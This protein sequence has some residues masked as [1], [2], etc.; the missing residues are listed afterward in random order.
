M[1]QR[2]IDNSVP[3]LVNLLWFAVVTIFV[4]RFVLSQLF[5]KSVNR[6][7]MKKAECARTVQYFSGPVGGQQVFS[8]EEW[9]S[10]PPPLGCN[11][12]LYQ[13]LGFFVVAL[14]LVLAF[15][16]KHSSDIVRKNILAFFVFATLAY[17]VDLLFFVLVVIPYQHIDFVETL[18]K[19]T[20]LRN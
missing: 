20:D 9:I 18:H 14:M 8:E 3:V 15:A 1:K 4:W 10:K 19:A 13:R 6:M 2:V 5:E 7:L 11:W 17:L 16:V 12:K